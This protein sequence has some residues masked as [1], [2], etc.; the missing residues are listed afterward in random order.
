MIQTVQYAQDPSLYDPDQSQNPQNVQDQSLEDQD[1][2]PDTQ[3]DEVPSLIVQDQTGNVIYQDPNDMN[4]SQSTQAQSHRRTHRRKHR[5]RRAHV[6]CE[7]GLEAAC[8]PEVDNNDC[9]NDSEPT[10]G[11]EGSGQ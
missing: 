7:T 11:E 3:E 8:G 2:I 9:D 5:K 6:G 4:Q 1:Q 10:S